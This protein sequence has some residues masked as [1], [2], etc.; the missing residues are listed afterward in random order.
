VLPDA[1]GSI[2]MRTRSG[3]RTPARPRAS[4]V[5]DVPTPVIATARN[6]AESRQGRD[7]A[8]YLEPVE[9]CR[10]PELIFRQD[11][12]PGQDA[13]RSSLA[14]GEALVWLRHRTMLLA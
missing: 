10:A 1:V 7:D 3:I 8:T 9:T 6:E 5:R 12:T 2:Q 13:E 14:H 11:P 4:G